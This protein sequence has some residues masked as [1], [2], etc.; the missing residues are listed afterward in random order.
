MNW[1]VM[2]HV[3]KV[4]SPV[5]KG[6]LGMTAAGTLSAAVLI[7]PWE[8]RRHVPYLD[9]IAY[10][11][12]WTV[13]DGI[14]GPAVVPG[15]HYDDLECDAMLAEEVTKHE[16]GLDQCLSVEPPLETK[17]AMI[18]FTFNVGVRAACRS[19]LVRMANAGDLKGSCNQ[20]SRWVFAGGRKI[21]GLENRRFRGD[22][23]R[24]SERSLCLKGLDPDYKIP[25]Y[26][27]WYSKYK[28]FKTRN[29]K[30]RNV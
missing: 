28:D 13:C 3:G 24:I 17:A 22:A 19:T 15:K 14:T 29:F 25:L 16:N 11:P 21:R 6:V 4:A 5:A 27:V 9:T 10:P 30:G 8:A 7:Q 18:S 2:R 23:T 1:N 12:V 26:E 20:L